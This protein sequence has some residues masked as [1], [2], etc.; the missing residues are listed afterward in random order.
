MLRQELFHPV[1]S[2]FPIALLVLTPF[3]QLGFIYSKNEKI[4]FLKVFCL[5]VGAVF[6]FISLFTGDDA[7][8]IIKND[9]CHLIEIYKHEESAQNG[10][11]V[12]IIALGIEVGSYFKFKKVLSWVQVLILIILVYVL[13]DTSHQGAMLVYERGAAV[14]TY[15]PDCP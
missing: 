2:H 1:I 14:K 9:F 4:E 8:E 5:Y 12:L 15:K 6:Y 10:L 13:A 11:I 3:L 7:M